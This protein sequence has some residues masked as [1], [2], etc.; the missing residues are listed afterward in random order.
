MAPTKVLLSLLLLAGCRDDACGLEG[1]VVSIAAASGQFAPGEYVI[2]VV[3]DDRLS[4]V[5]CAA[6]EAGLDSCESLPGPEMSAGPPIHATA[7]TGEAGGV[8][9]LTTESEHALCEPRASMPNH[10][11]VIVRRAGEVLVAEAWAPDYDVCRR[12]LCR[13]MYSSSHEI[14]LD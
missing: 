13:R 6:G 3:L 11:S 4:T 12:D 8:V 7:F 2:E 14:V 1:L 5:V 10:A 9:L